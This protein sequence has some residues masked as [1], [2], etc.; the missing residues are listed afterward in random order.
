MTVTCTK[1]ILVAGFVTAI[2]SNC[3]R[4]YNHSHWIG[5]LIESIGVYFVEK[6]GYVIKVSDKDKLL[7][8]TITNPSGVVLIKTKERASVFQFWVLYW[9]AENERLWVESSDIGIF[10]WQKNR[11]QTGFIE[12]T[13]TSERKDLIKM[14]PLEFFNSFPDTDKEF[15][16]KNGY[17][18]HS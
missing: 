1:K 17:G 3:S 5:G 7:D 10:L 9:D 4:P 18:E 12:T 8:Y 11:D 15:C 13:I 6:S 16:K 2:F 14:I